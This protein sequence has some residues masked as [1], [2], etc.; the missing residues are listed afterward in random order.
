MS[1]HQIIYACSNCGTQTL[2]W[3]GRCQE[4]GKWGTLI[5]QTVSVQKS[6]EKTIKTE[7]G[8]TISF[9]E[10]KNESVE[11]IQ[12]EIKEFDRVMG[13]GIIQGSLTLI[14][15]EPG[16]GKSTLAL[17]IAEKINNTLYVSGEE[18]PAQIKI[19]ADRLGI[20]GDNIKFSSDTEIEKVCALIEKIKP[21]LTIVDSIQTVHSTEIE[22]ETGFDVVN[23]KEITNEQ[24]A[25]EI[26]KAHIK[27]VAD[28]ASDTVLRCD[29]ILMDK[30]L[31]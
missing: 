17:Q 10:I 21:G 27:W 3:Q 31:Y 20:K 16:A 9:D 26:L 5:E 24:K 13:G 2:K 14:G 23:K 12:T 8:K 29:K 15:G 1:K 6:T 11:R 28:W 30:N 19:R 22:N 4:C 7:P 18:S 25:K